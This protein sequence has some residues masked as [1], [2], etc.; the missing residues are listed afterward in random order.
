MQH[1]FERLNENEENEMQLNSVLEAVTFRYL[2][3][4][5]KAQYSHNIINIFQYSQ[6]TANIHFQ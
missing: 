3:R 2:N 1:N 5:F 6:S 4:R